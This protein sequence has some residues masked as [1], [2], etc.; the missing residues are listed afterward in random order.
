[1]KHPLLFVIALFWT[2]LLLAQIEE[3][4]R[5][6]QPGK[7]YV[8]CII[9]D[10]YETITENVLLKEASTRIEIVPAVYEEVEEEVLVKE[11]Y[12]VL[13]ILPAK[14]DTTVEELL[15]KERAS[16]LEYVP[17]TFETVTEQILVQ[18]A[19]MNWVKGKVDKNCLSENDPE[20]CKVWCLNETPAKYKTVTRQILKSPG[21][22]IESP[23]PAEYRSIS[24]ALIQSPAQIEENEV[25]AEYRI[26]VKTV[27]AQ[28]AMTKEF[29][30]PAEYSTVTKRRLVNKGGVT[31][32]VEVMCGCTGRGGDDTI[33]RIQEALKK[34]GYFS[35]PIDS[36]LGPK[37]RR[38]LVQWQKDKGLPVG[39]IN[40]ETLR[41][42]GLR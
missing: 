1:M 7:C 3:F 40:I 5:N 8:K 30:I 23:I 22:M 10:Q 38:A 16:R 18:P 20:A 36:V 42:L 9:P 32:W 33:V 34:R 6:V 24:K 37:T 26:V 41:S 27:L 11:G 4:P 29:E 17:P 12:K 19:S 39:N 25:P 35:G 28:P 31:N 2:S 14:F 21:S 15:V 13:N